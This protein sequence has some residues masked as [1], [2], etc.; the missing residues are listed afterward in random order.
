[1]EV[2]QPLQILVP[3]VM[4][5]ALFPHLDRGVHAAEP[6]RGVALL[7]AHSRERLGVVAARE[8]A[9]G[10]V[11]HERLA[12]G[13]EGHRGVAGRLEEVERLAFD[14]LELARVKRGLAPERRRAAIVLGE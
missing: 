14:A 10:L 1:M 7:L 3:A 13:V 8:V 9:R 4:L 2:G 11:V 5:E 12:V 6:E